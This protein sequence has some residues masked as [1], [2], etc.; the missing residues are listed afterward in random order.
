[1]QRILRFFLPVDGSSVM[2]WWQ[3]A[4]MWSDANFGKVPYFII[5]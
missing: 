1:M 5:R 3:K 4:L 2:C